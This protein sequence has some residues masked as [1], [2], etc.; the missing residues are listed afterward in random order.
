MTD[1]VLINAARR[2][3]TCAIGRTSAGGFSGQ[4]MDWCAETGWRMEICS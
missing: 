2:Q 4:Y 3:R 1:G